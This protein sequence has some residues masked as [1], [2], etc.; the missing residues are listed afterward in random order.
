MSGLGEAERREKGRMN[1]PNAAAP[2]PRAAPQLR[3][4]PAFP[5]PQAVQG[6]NP[7]KT[8][9]AS[10]SSH[11]ARLCCHQLTAACP[12]WP[13]PKA[14]CSVRSSTE[15]KEWLGWKIISKI[16]QFQ[17]RV[18][19][20]CNRCC[21]LRVPMAAASLALGTSRDGV[22]YHNVAQLGSVPTVC[23]SIN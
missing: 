18:T 16:I 21:Q 17:T 22:P 5:K 10:S 7:D 19:N 15:I 20:H 14:I 9:S 8:S 13:W 11:T 1:Q 6:A 23:T 12:A 4:P 3:S 2:S